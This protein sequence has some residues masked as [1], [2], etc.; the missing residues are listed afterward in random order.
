MQKEKKMPRV[1]RELLIRKKAGCKHCRHFDENGGNGICY[2]TFAQGQSAR[3]ARNE[4][5]YCGMAGK[6]F[7]KIVKT[8]VPRGHEPSTELEAK[9][10]Y[11]EEELAEMSP[12]KRGAIKRKQNQENKS[13]GVGQGS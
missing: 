8:D 5:K 11:T 13:K 12:Q 4:E 2:A 9:T 1:S 3:G 10:E 6:L 7:Q